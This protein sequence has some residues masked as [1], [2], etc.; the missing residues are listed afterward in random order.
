MT[1]VRNVLFGFHKDCIDGCFAA[2][3]LRDAYKDQPNVR[4]RYMPLPSEM[5]AAQARR[6]LESIRPGDEVVIADVSPPKESLCVLLGSELNIKSLT[7]FDHHESEVERLLSYER[8]NVCGCRDGRVKFYLDAKAPSAASM[9][10]NTLLPKRAPQTFLKLV[11]RME[12][13]SRTLHDEDLW[14]AAYTDTHAL[15][16]E[17]RAALPTPENLD[18]IFD[19]LIQLAQDMEQKDLRVEMAL[20]GESIVSE[21]LCNIKKVFGSSMLYTRARFAP[22]EERRWVVALNAA[23]PNYG[24]IMNHYLLLA[25]DEMN[26]ALGK[27]EAPVAIA[28]FLNKNNHVHVSLRSNGSPN[29]GDI[30]AFWASELGGRDKQGKAL[31]SGGG[32]DDAACVQIPSPLRLLKRAPRY[33]FE[34][35]LA[36]ESA[37]Q[38][39]RANGL[40][41]ITQQALYQSATLS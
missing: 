2:A 4:I 32:H 35:M 25:A 12:D 18:P 6:F 26:K 21:Q 31:G 40:P 30:A 23:I 27:T 29:V 1:E 37:L 33:T 7:L 28:W 38:A 17:D 39:R 34:Q 8:D 10:W 16:P 41:L 11:G 15:S 14:L 22:G 24:R 5:P 19:D 13:T 36:K 20:R 9:V 3:G